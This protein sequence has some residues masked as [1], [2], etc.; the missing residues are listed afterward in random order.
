[1]Y[2]RGGEIILAPLKPEPKPRGISPPLGKQFLKCTTPSKC[3]FLRGNSCLLYNFDITRAKMDI[4]T[5]RTNAKQR[6][7]SVR[8]IHYIELMGK[9]KDLSNS[10][11]CLKESILIDEIY[12]KLEELREFFQRPLSELINDVKL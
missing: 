1:M 8:Y 6:K 7:L 11:V 2:S 5:H 12:D 4:C 9:V 3:K 10:N